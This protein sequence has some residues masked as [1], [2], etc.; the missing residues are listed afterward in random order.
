MAEV[1]QKGHIS[2]RGGDAVAVADEQ[3]KGHRYGRHGKTTA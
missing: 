2:W 1:H 3:H